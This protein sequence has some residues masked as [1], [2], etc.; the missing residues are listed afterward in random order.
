MAYQDHLVAVPAARGTI[1]SCWMC[2][3]RLRADQMVADGGPACP[4][5]RWYCL[6]TRGCTQRWTARVSAVSGS[7]RPW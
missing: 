1:E 4:D 7:P 6:D 5:V 2:G 3:I